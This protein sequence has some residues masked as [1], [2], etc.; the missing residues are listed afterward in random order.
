MEPRQSTTKDL[1]AVLRLAWPLILSNSF[2]TVQIMVDRMVLSWSSGADV[3]AGMMSALA[4]WAPLNLMMYTVGYVSTFVAQYTGAGRLDRIGPVVWQAL[5]LAIVGGF[6][7]MLLLPLAGPLF[8]LAGHE[9]ALQALEATYFRYLCFSALPVLIN[10]AACGFF[11]GQGHSRTVL[12]VNG[13]GLIANVILCLGLVEGRWGWPVMGIAGAGIATIAGSTFSAFLSMTLL[14]RPKNRA[15][16]LWTY[17]FDRDLFFRLLRFGLPNGLLVGL[18]TLAFSVFLSFVGLFGAIELAGTT[19]AFT[20][21]LLV[22]L[23]IM[24]IGQ[25]VGILVGQHLGEDRPDA[26]ARATRAGLI[27][28]LGLTAALGLP[29]LLLPETLADW[30]RSDNNPEQWAR[31]AALVP[32]LLRFVVVYCLFDALNLIYSH[33]LRGAG[34]TRFVTAVSMA[35][36]WPVM[37]LPTWFAW[38]LGWGLYAAWTFASLYLVLLSMVFGFRYYQGRWRSM[39]VIETT[40]ATLN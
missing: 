12:F 39:R 22:Y 8:A 17:R 23:P 34:D 16:G 13:A 21:N 11:A 9:P 30:F 20:L 15:F 28:A 10:A 14:L 5:F 32:P 24:G 31:I 19:I 40:P 18:D 35:L 36:A 27:L 4:F 7:F 29:Y 37:V 2:W 1:V 33:A 38:N 25:A 6:G 26:A 3:A